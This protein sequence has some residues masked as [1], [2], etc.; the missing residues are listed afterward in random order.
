LIVYLDSSLVVSLYGIDANSAAAQTAIQQCSDVPVITNLCQIEVL[1][2]FGLQ[3]FRK[4]VS[5]Q[6]SAFSIRNFDEDLQAGIFRL[7]P[8]P[9]SAFPRARQV[10]IQFTA[11][12]GIRAVDLLHVAA[13]LE[14]GADTLFSFDL[15][16]RELAKSVGLRLNPFST[17]IR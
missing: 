15:P 4:Q 11:Q 12:I 2:A 14:L 8:L 1:N 17:P 7:K 3:A 10:S 9:E 13:A 5:L 16:Q 6:R